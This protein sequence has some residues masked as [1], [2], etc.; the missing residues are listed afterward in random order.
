MTIEGAVF[1][2]GHWTTTP[3]LYKEQSVKKHHE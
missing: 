3:K 2:T 1:C